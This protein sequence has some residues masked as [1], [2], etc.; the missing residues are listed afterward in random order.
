[1]PYALWQAEAVRKD[2]QKRVGST[3][4]YNLNV[5]SFSKEP[6]DVKTKAYLVGGGIGS[7][8]AAAFTI[9]D[10]GL[11][12]GNISILEAAPW[13]AVEAEGSTTSS[14]NAT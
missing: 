6:D 13:D 10:A 5:P 3:S 1:M 8:A 11:P 14:S 4:D 12:G 9:R 7:L 2:H